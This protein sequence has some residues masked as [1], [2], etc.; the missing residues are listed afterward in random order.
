M[1]DG[2][3]APFGSNG[4]AV[5]VDET[6]IGKEP[7]VE[8]AKNARGGSH[9]MKMLTLV[10]RDTKRARSVVVDD[11]TKA[12]ILPILRENTGREALILTDEARQYQSLATSP[13]F[14]GQDRLQHSRDEY[15]RPGFPEVHTNTVEGFYSIFKRGMKTSRKLA[16]VAAC[17]CRPMRDEVEYE[18]DTGAPARISFAQGGR[19]ALLPKASAAQ[20][21]A[22][23]RRPADILRVA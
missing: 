16:K 7:G 9:K 12:T 1:R 5:E 23:D 19:S 6:F 4:G 11:L 8:K 15:V 20:S 17:V 13:D 10:D 3:L 21:T 18:L 14:G 2:E 22:V